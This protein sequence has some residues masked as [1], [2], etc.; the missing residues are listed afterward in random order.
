MRGL[1]V[2]EYHHYPSYTPLV[3]ATN[4]FQLGRGRRRFV[5]QTDHRRLTCPVAIFA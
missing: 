1:R 3:S 2:A 4:A 5:A